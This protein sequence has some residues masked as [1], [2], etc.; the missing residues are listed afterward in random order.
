MRGSTSANQANKLNSCY[1]SRYSP[2]DLCI[3]RYTVVDVARQRAAAIVQRPSA[4]RRSM[5]NTYQSVTD[6]IV[7]MLESGTRPWARPWTNEAP[8]SAPL[9]RP[10]RVNGVPYTGA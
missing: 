4:R 3:D 7:A 10:L 6:L 9:A 5:S 2:L 8:L 1:W